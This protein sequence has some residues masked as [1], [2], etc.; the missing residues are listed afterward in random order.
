MFDGKLGHKLADLGIEAEVTS[1]LPGLPEELILM[2]LNDQTGYFHQV[3]GWN[4]NCAVMGAALAELSF[5]SRIDSDLDSLIVVDA[6][7]TGDPLLDSALEEIAAEPEQHDVQFWVERFATRA[8]EAIDQ[9]LDR[10][11]EMGIVKHE[12]GDFWTVSGAFSEGSAHEFIKARIARALFTDEIP[13]P[14]DIVVI[15]LVDT[16]GVFQFIFDLDE[17]TKERI[18]KIRRMD[19]IARSIAAAV[20]H[21]VV[22]SLFVRTPL[23]PRIP[24]VP[25]RRLLS[26]P[27]LRKGFISSAFAD[28]AKEYGPVFEVR[29]PIGKPIIFLAGLS[30]NRWA[31][32]SAR[33]YLK[34]RPYL[35]GI[36]K[37]YGAI[38]VLPALDGG[39]HFRMRKAYAPTCSHAWLAGNLDQLFEQTRKVMA[40]WT[41]GETYQARSMCRRMINGQVSHLQAGVDS[42]DMIDDLISFKERALTVH[43][44]EALPE[45]SLKTPA[46]RRRAKLIDEFFERVRDHQ[47]VALRAGCPHSSL[48]GDVLSLHTSDPQ[49]MP[50]TNLRFALTVTAQLAMYFGDT[51]SFAIYDMVTRPELHDKVRSEADAL[52]D[53]GDPTIEDLTPSAIDVTHRL[54]QESLRMHPTLAMSL[55]D[56]VNSC[57]VEGY[58]L[59][60]GS[61]VCIAQSATHYM[62]DVFPDPFSFDIDRYLPPREEHRG[63][64]YAPYGLGTHSCLGMQFAALQTA[65]NLLM[66]AHYFDVSVSPSNY[67]LKCSIVPTVKPNRKLN[68]HIAEQRRELPA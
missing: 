38:G 30:T 22:K 1:V 20:E 52:F 27:H 35:G 29:P 21:N 10:L 55:R 8:E 53:N 34:T 14:R 36:E 44:M 60:I 42:Q 7:E 58:E 68:F 28:L 26:D 56:V 46:M 33:K 62:K 9:I 37:T 67:V 39:D 48:V 15:A 24:Q 19:L 50:E 49:L 3:P 12:Y 31:H 16:C 2:L 6:T 45:A 32:R 4:L 65:V 17:G 25:L 23:S 57:V 40:T 51:L 47:A 11:V 59:P 41:V 18:A 5:R 54:I 66:I 13:D 61:R 64:G 43:V 63:L